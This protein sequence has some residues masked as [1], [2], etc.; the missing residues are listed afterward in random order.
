LSFVWGHYIHGGWERQDLEEKRGPLKSQPTQADLSLA[1]QILKRLLQNESQMR[2]PSMP[3]CWKVTWIPSYKCHLPEQAVSK[4]SACS[5]ALASGR[6][7]YSTRGSYYGAP[8]SQLMR[9]FNS[10]GTLESK[11]CISNMF[12]CLISYQQRPTHVR[13]RLAQVLRIMLHYRMKRQNMNKARQSWEKIHS[14]KQSLHFTLQQ[15]LF[16]YWVYLLHK[17]K[18][19]NLYMLNHPCIFLMKLT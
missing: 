2:V 9:F 6:G 7:P 1:G 4:S 10:L 17:T 8:R 15:R 16:Y 12:S 14:I 3:L 19:I 18:F 13:K 5:Q 11:L